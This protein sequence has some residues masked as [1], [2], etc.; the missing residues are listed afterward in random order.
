MANRIIAK[1]HKGDKVKVIAGDSKGT[2]ATVV[3]VDAAKSKV[4]V[5]GV[6][7]VTRHRKPTA[8][9]PEGGIEKFEAP[10]HISNVMVVD[11]KTNQPTRIG[12]RRDGGKKVRVAKKSG[13]VIK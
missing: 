2:V 4:I 6:H 8:M 11:P 9:N 10:I 7:I 3:S 1:I 5:E 12:I 13:Q